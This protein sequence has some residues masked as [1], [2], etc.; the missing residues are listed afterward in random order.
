MLFCGAALRLV[1]V[2]A[3]KR[4]ELRKRFRYSINE[5]LSFFTLKINAFPRDFGFSI[6]VTNG[7][8]FFY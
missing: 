8:A 4:A 5:N 7:A 3:E 2:W 1:P 6:K